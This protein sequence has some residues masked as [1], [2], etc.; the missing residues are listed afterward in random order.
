MSTSTNSQTDVSG[1]R[2]ANLP[3]ALG[4]AL[5][6]VVVLTVMVVPVAYAFGWSSGSMLEDIL[7]AWIPSLALALGTLLRLGHKEGTSLGL[8]LGSVVGLSLVSVLAVSPMRGFGLLLPPTIGL[9]LGLLDGVGRRLFEG[10]RQG[11]TVSMAIGFAVSL[12]LVARQGWT[13]VFPGLLIGLMIGTL[14][15]M[16]RDNVRGW[17]GGLRRPPVILVAVVV[18]LLVGMFFLLRS[19]FEA[20]KSSQL[21]SGSPEFEALGFVALL[22]VLMPMACFSFG[23]AL[24]R[25]LRPRFEVLGQLV[26]YL[27]AM[28]V[29]IGAFAI[30]YS[31][32]LLVFAGFYGSLYRLDPGH[33]GTPELVPARVDWIFFA[34]YSAVG[35]TYS[36]LRPVSAIA[37]GTVA[38]QSLLGIGWAVVVF[39]AV[40]SHL[41]PRLAAISQRVNDG[42]EE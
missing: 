27:R 34:L 9:A 39:A 41:Q 20:G 30:G 28:Y 4:A 29:P 8:V 16:R 6:Q 3:R 19:E 22:M 31:V 25:W 7:T 12:G 13:V 21:M 42:Y 10:F 33:F 11:I 17:R 35:T 38:A 2:M 36:A 26:L 18:L 14:I 37:N 15:G 40:M 24:G 32:I 23:S 1:L 5:L